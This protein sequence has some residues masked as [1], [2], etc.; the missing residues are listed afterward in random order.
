MQKGRELYRGKAKTL[1]TTDNEKLLIMAYRDDATAFNALKKAS[2]PRKGLVNNYFNAFIMQYL[3]SQGINTHFLKLISNTESLVK[4]VEIIPLECVVRNIAAGNLCKRLGI[5]EKTVI[6][7][8]LF[9]F[10]LKND[11]LGDPIINDDHVRLFNFAS[12]KEIILIKKLSFD[13]NNLLIPLFLK[14]NLSLVDFKLEFGRYEGK[15]ILGD[16]FTPDGCRLWDIDTGESL[17]KD[18]FRQD[19]GNVIESYEIVAK[20]LQISLPS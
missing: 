9:E 17:D 12:L 20:R 7:P 18:R 2:L 14:A 13:I 6:S 19:L 1:Y 15:I 8:P 5:S 11:K 3:E 10:Y 16:E 4:N